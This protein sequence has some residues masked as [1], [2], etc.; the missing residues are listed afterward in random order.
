MKLEEIEDY[1]YDDA[2]SES[3][4]KWAKS[5]C[6]TFKSKVQYLTYADTI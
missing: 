4:E 1:F 5:H 6:G 3:I 2:L